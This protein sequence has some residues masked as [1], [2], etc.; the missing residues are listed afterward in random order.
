MGLKGYYR[1][2]GV[3][4]DVANKEIKKVYRQ[5]ALRYHPDHNPGSPKQAEENFKE[6]NE[7][8]EVLG[9]EQRRQHYDHVTAWSNYRQ[10]RVVVENIFEDTFTDGMG[11]DVIREIMKMFA[12]R[13]PGFRT[14]NHR[15]SWGCNR[16]RGR[17]CRHE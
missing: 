8:Y 9:D 16:Q 6:I 7:A 12:D 13:D 1:I 10:N 14:F 17:G 15:R 5:L 3:S 4:R 11:L 2:L